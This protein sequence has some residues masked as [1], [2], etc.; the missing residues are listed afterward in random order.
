[1][2]SLF[3]YLETAVVLVTMFTLLVA[4]HELGHYLFA[5]LFNMGVEEFAIGFGKQ[6]IYEWMKRTYIVPIR[7]GEVAQIESTNPNRFDVESTGRRA[8]E[9][10][11]E[12]DTPQGKAL[13]ETTRFTVR[14]WPLGGFVRIK[15]MLP[16]DDG[17]ETTIA[18]GFYSKAPWQRLIVLFAGPM[19]SVIA[20]ILILIPLYI[21]SGKDQLDNSPV[22]GPVSKKGPAAE[23]GLKEKDVVTAIDGKAVKSFYDINVIVR[24]S[25]DKRLK[26]SIL[27]DD[28]PLELTVIPVLDK[29]PSPVLGPGLEF[30]GDKRAQAKLYTHF[31]TK[32]VSV[33][34]GQAVSM[35]VSRPI[36]AVTGLLDMIRHPSTVKDQMGGPLSITA[37]T[38]ETVKLGIA[39]IFELAALLS[40]SVGILNL[41]P[42]MPLDGGQM[43]LAF[44]EMFRRG[45][46]LS[47]HVQNLVNL[48][49]M[50][51]MGVLIL[52]VFYIDITRMIDNNS[53]PK[54]PPV[55]KTA[56]P[57]PSKDV[58][59]SPR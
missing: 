25:A 3:N 5:R 57:S 28:K 47:M 9:D 6:T 27:R 37:A 45:R 33:D 13:K 15:G 10:M 39:P 2:G 40:I 55:S 22:I 59:Q 46:R 38:Y 4:A 14:P 20:G 31:R 34:F 58:S 41:L 8:P 32:R 35:A 24:D 49:G 43:V 50:A 51:F 11:V 18:G 36:Q 42:V 26:F 52:S 7:P 16:E 29:N 19:F 21:V 17:S 1:M 54:D 23:A 48:F 30:T 12:I 53:P 44:A 56:R